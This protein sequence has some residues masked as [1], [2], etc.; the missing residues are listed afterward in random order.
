[1]KIAVATFAFTMTIAP[2]AFAG[3]YYNAYG[4]NPGAAFAGGLIGGM[5]GTALAPQPQT[6]VI[7][8]V[9]TP[10]TPT[11]PPAT[12]PAVTNY[13]PVPLPTAAYQAQPPGSNYWWCEPYAR[14]YPATQTCPVP[15]EPH[16]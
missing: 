3:C 14:F 6:N 8:V 12:P 1:M 7:V 9:P 10:P 5:L 15:W 11:K 16:R 4:C 13:P 2:L